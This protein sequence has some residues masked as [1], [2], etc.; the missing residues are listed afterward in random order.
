M[1]GI[2]KKSVSLLI[3]SVMLFTTLLISPINASAAQSPL[4]LEDSNISI[5]ADPENV[6]NQQDI[7]DFS[8]NGNKLA[9]L[10]GIQPYKRSTSSTKYYL[11]LPSYSRKKR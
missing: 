11:F 8:A 3:V 9:A 2:L 6:L 1:K 7:T 10:G 4:T 5:W